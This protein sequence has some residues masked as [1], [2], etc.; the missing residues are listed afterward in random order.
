M[1]RQNKPAFDEGTAGRFP[2]TEPQPG[3]AEETNDLPGFD[4]SPPTDATTV[5]SLPAAKGIM[6]PRAAWNRYWLPALL[7][8]AGTFLAYQRVW[9]AGFVWD[10]DVMLTQNPFVHAA[11]GLRWIWFSTKLPDYFP[12]TSTLLWLEWRLWGANPLGYHL[13]NV[14]LHVLSAVLLWRVLA[15][16]EIPG[17]WLAAAMFAVHPVNVESV[18][19][20]TEHKNT[21]AM[22]FSAITVLAYLRFE[23][24][25]RRRWYGV[26][27]GAFV[28]ALLSKTLVAPLP[29]VLLG[30]AWWRRGRVDRRDVWRSVPFF[31]AAALLALVAVWFQYH[32]VIGST[33]VR[34]DSF[35][36]R[37]A[38]AGWAVWFYLYKAVLPVKLVF[39]YPR[40]RIDSANLLSYV[41]G[42]LLVAGLLVCWRYRRQWGK[43]WLFGLG[44]FVVMLLPVLGFF[45][46]SFM[47][48]SLVADHWQYFAVVGPVALVAAA[49][50][51]ALGRFEGKRPFLRPALCG[52]LLLVLGV[53]TWRQSGMYT[54]LETLWQTTLAQNPNCPM[55]YND[56]GNDL[57]RKGRV[58]EAIADFQK[59]LAIQPD[60][61]LAHYNFGYALLQ[62]G[63]V[64]DAISHFKKAVAIQPD[65]VEAH[66]NLGNALLQKG[67]VDE[68][69]THFQKA[70]EIQPDFAEAHGNLGDALLRKGQLDDAIAHFQKALEIQ[71]EYPAALNNLGVALVQKG[72]EGEATALFEKA[73]G[74]QPDFVEAH[75]NLGKVLLRKGQARQAMAHYRAALKIRPD[76]SETLSNLLWLLTTFPEAPPSP[77]DG[78]AGPGQ[79]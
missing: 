17:A 43:A 11:D 45:N 24:T 42:L 8:I 31:A 67:Q 40:W 74:L 77:T 23:D 1:K 27:V 47:R 52:T 60:Y 59:A 57:L 73:L 48:F 7:L 36:S 51:T 19:W 68:A 75:V 54:S 34:A 39:V 49:I 66:H 2:A 71:P 63:Q 65:F 29:L 9:R 14:L 78:T 18:A 44:Y 38:G 46:I 79:R 5:P 58:D 37:V 53:L 72:K 41:P 30:L 56:L 13:V 12:M 6:E 21:L 33:I 10:D 16:L 22:L 28:L 4:V 15:R 70:S 55:A 62:K 76:D 50:T 35:W 64:D 25:G 3:N 32:R 69:I 61:E 26:A 20:I